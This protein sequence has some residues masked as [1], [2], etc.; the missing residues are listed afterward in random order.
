[1]IRRPPRSTLFPYT[2]L[3]RSA[4]QPASSALS[5]SDEASPSP[6]QRRFARRSPCWEG[7]QQPTPSLRVREELAIGRLPAS[8][9]WRDRTLD[10]RGR[11]RLPAES[12]RADPEVGSAWSEIRLHPPSSHVP[13]SPHRRG[14]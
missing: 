7:Q 8:A 9:P 11:A 1:M 14:R 5:G 2:T 10:V 13:T 12:H 4:T 6:S 3:F